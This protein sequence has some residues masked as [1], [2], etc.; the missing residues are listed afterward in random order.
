[1]NTR[2]NYMKA[3][4]ES[5]KGFLAVHGYLGQSALGKALIDLVFLR[6]SQINHCAYCIDMHSQDLIKQ[7]VA[8]E[9]LMLVSAWREAGAVFTDREQA[10]LAWAE[11]VANVADTGVPDEDYAAASAEFDDRELSDLSVAI[12]LM[13]AFNRLG[14]AFRNTPAAASRLV[15]AA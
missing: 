5:I 10:A 12:A 1:M 9:K 2:I 4:P 3:A 6:V 7:G 15:R 14:V 13:S 11:S 8:V